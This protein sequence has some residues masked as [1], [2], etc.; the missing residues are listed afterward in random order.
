VKINPWPYTIIA[1]FILFG[2]GT[3]SL[4]T[5]ACSQKVDLVSANYYEQEILYQKQ[6]DRMQR[7]DSPAV[8]PAITY[9]RTGGRIIISMPTTDHSGSISGYIQLYRPSAAGLDRDQPLAL[10][11]HGTQTLDA[12]KLRSG[13]WKV[14][15]SWTAQEREYFTEQSLVIQ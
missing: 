7:S 5:L 8:R 11:S 15:L 4:V 9:D 1:T 2:I 13:L 14:R 3:A 10:D 12:R 6:I